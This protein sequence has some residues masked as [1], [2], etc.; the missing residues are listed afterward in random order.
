MT[1]CYDLTKKDKPGLSNSVDADQMP[2]TMMYNQDLHWLLLIQDIL[3]TSAGGR[4]VVFKFKG[5]IFL[6]NR[7]FFIQERFNKLL[8]SINMIIKCGSSRS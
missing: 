7:H 5:S 2:Q 3:D 6:K 4:V 8:Y 1:L